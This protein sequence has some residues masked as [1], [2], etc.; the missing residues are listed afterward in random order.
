MTDAIPPGGLL[1]YRIVR[2]DGEIVHSDWII[3]GDQAD[4]HARRIAEEQGEICARLTDEGRT[5]T[6]E[7]W[8]PDLPPDFATMRFGTNAAGMRNPTAV[9]F[10]ELRAI[11]TEDYKAR[12]RAAGEDPDE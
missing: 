3:E 1:R 4:A 8:D 6:I 2:D 11:N 10:D 12:L 9:R 7:V 5:F